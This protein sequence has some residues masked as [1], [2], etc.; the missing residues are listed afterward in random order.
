METNSFRELVS[1]DIVPPKV[2]WPSRLETRYSNLSRTEDWVSSIGYR[3]SRIGDQDAIMTVSSRW[4]PL[5][6]DINKIVDR[7]L[8]TAN[9]EFSRQ[10][11]MIFPVVASTGQRRCKQNTCHLALQSVLGNS[12]IKWGSMACKVV[13]LISLSVGFRFFR[14]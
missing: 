4:K 6:R 5:S 12:V 2:S 9:F 3:G 1:L 7:L 13:E 8:K 14:N 10:I 11:K